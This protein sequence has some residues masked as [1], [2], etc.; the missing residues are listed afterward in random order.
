MKRVAALLLAL[1]LLLPM[2]ALAQDAPLFRVV[3]NN[4]L[5]LRACASTDCARVGLAP[6]GTELPVYAVE[7]DWYQ[8]QVDGELVWLAGWLTTRVTPVAPPGPTRAPDEVFEG[9]AIH[10]DPNTR[11]VIFLGVEELY[12]ELNIILGGDRS[13]DVS[14]AFYPPGERTP[15]TVTDRSTVDLDGSDGPT[16][17][18]A[19]SGIRVTANQPYRLQFELDDRSSL[20]EWYPAHSGGAGIFIMCNSLESLGIEIAQLPP[21]AAPV[22]TPAPARLLEMGETWRDSSTGCNLIVARVADEAG[23]LAV[24]LTGEGR[25]EAR[26]HVYQPGANVALP[27][28]DSIEGSVDVMGNPVIIRTWPEI[29]RWEP[30]RYRFEI[31]LGDASSVF[32]WEMTR[33]GEYS[34]L[35]DCGRPAAAAALAPGDAPARM[36]VSEEIFRDSETGCNL[37]VSG[38]DGEADLYVLLLGQDR[39]EARLAV[40]LP[41]EST[42]LAPERR[43]IN[44][45]PS[46]G[47]AYISDSFSPDTRW[48][49]GLYR[50]ELGLGDVSSVFDWEMTRL[51]DYGLVVDCDRGASPLAA[52]TPDPAGATLTAPEQILE[53]DVMLADRVTG[54][55]VL[56]SPESPDE[57]LNLVFS[58]ERRAEV[59]ARVYRPGAR[60]PLPYTGRL[61][62]ILG[63]DDRPV[64]QQYYRADQAWPAGQYRLE[65]ELAG[66][67]SAFAWQM[68]R[69]GDQTMQILCGLTASGPTPTSPAAAAPAPLM[70]QVGESQRDAQTGCL[71][72]LAPESPD[73]DLNLLLSGERRAEVVARLYRPGARAPLTYTSRLNRSLGDDDEPVIHQYYRADQDWPAG[74]YR[75][76]LELDGRVS[77]FIWHMEAPKDQFLLILCE[78]SPSLSATTAPPVRAAGP[79]RVLETEVIYRDDHSGCDILVEAEG[80][81]GDLNLVLAGD[82]REAV[83]A[84]VFLPGMDTPLDWTGQHPESYVD[85]GEPILFQYYRI[86]APWPDGLYQLEIELDGVMT[87]VSWRLERSRDQV[88]IVDCSTPENRLPVAT[89]TPT[90]TSTPTA[91]ATPTVT[92]TPRPTS[93]PAPVVLEPGRFQWDRSTGCEVQLHPDGLDGDLN[94]VLADSRQEDVEVRIF[95]PDSTWDTSFYGRVRDNFEENGEPFIWQ[96]YV[97][98]ASWRAGTYRLEITLDGHTSNF[99]WELERNG[100]Q[101]IYVYCDQPAPPTPRPTETPP[102]TSTPTPTLTPTSPAQTDLRTGALYLDEATGCDVIIFELPP[103]Q[104]D[105]KDLWVNRTGELRHE[106][107]V[108]VWLPEAA[109]PLPVAEEYDDP[110]AGEL[111]VWQNYSPRTDWR[112]GVYRFEV[113]LGDASSVLTWRMERAAYYAIRVSCEQ[114]AGPAPSV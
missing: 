82:R 48:E 4:N 55:Y 47:E 23:D 110:D 56:L 75:L 89:L 97:T 81:D 29:P 61:D 74:L 94:L 43:K 67:V 112:N 64:I 59:L 9:K 80:L 45:Q 38:E 40:Y 25:R 111:L 5:N 24:L 15:L 8:V 32:A 16:I 91:T 51:G 104:A 108:R 92:P 99:T 62:R 41:G 88:I 84:R 105:W 10:L 69:P 44:D 66:R 11:C 96:Y 19:F 53:A 83:V 6:G 31:G 50:I 103:E 90:S 42:P 3:T 60:A 34:L 93:T 72:R 2:L 21:A 71:V 14:F 39:R 17:E 87:R 27:L 54:C 113:S 114:Q 18:N 102:T 33:P 63:D 30:G 107:T 37:Y 101:I 57:D 36:L 22:T 26:V 68:E 1:G 46:T 100:D 86:A 73:E 77:A 35:V 79:V 85:T 12:D 98:D 65:V 49:P 106:F 7:G 109:S 20:L 78:R 58:G 13:N 52:P 28:A 76:D 70:L 95:R